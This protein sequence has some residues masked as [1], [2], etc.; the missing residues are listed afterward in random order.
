M[1]GIGARIPTHGALNNKEPTIYSIQGCQNLSLATKFEF[2]KCDY[3]GEDKPYVNGSMKANF[4]I[5]KRIKSTYSN[6][7]ITP[8]SSLMLSLCSWFTNTEHS[9]ELSLR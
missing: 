9:S 7:G 1:D 4:I 6:V 5:G 8:R 3:V 2:V